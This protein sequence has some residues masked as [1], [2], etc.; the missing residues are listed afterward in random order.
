MIVCMST[1]D[2]SRAEQA[3]LA[4]QARWGSQVAEKAAAV[5]I[6]RA[7]ELP[8]VL[9]AQLHLATSDPEASDGE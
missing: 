9:R 6:E 4:A 7:A 3:R 8:E 2:T 1:A 5:V